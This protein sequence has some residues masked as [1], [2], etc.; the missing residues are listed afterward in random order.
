VKE[1]FTVAVNQLLAGRDAAIA[2]YELG[3]A[4]TLDTTELE[5]QQQELLSEMEVLNG[6]IQQMIR[7]NA[8]VAQDQTEYNKRFDALSQKF[9]EAEGKRMLSCNRS[10]TSETG[11]ARWRTSYGF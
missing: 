2:A 8:A 5:A 4:K 1:R 6:M 7:Q 9:K 10:V 11:A 3:M